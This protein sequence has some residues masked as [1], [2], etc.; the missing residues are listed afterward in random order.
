VA[1]AKKKLLPKDF[2]ALLE[3]GDMAALRAVFASRE[4]DARGFARS[5]ALAHDACPDEL[6][7]WL[8]AQGADL[9]ARSTYGETPLLARAA[10]RY[11]GRISVLLELGADIHAVDNEGNTSLHQAAGASNVA[12]VRTLL[13]HG[14]RPD[15]RNQFGLTP[16]EWA[17]Q[18]CQNI[19]I[20]SLA[21][22]A[23]ML[24]DAAPAP[25]TGLR[26]LAA[27][28]IG[29]RATGRPG[30]TRE[31]KAAVQRIG[32][33]FEFHRPGFNR[34][35]LDA[36]DAGLDHLYRLFDVPP[37]PRRK[38]YDGGSPILAE[39]SAWEDR[40]QELWELLVPP[41]G[42]ATTVQG[43]VI[44]ASGRIRVE[45]DL[46]GAGNWDADYRKM[47]S[48]LLRHLGSGTPLSEAEI[49]E[50]AAL[51]RDVKSSSYDT[52]R[53]CQLATIWVGLNPQPIELPPPAYTR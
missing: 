7:R 35:L 2:G 25:A 43:E 3:A 52:R 20:E 11:G 26:G 28:L 40:H 46:N 29:G 5:T 32:T 37:V 8:V 41:S 14:A 23:E 33:N 6:S 38:I 16:L 48:A 12:S 34:D 4:I 17:L 51:L 18:R 19:D 22:I 44:R 39:A 13:Q 9:E 15:Q 53:L 36:A 45:I 21:P 1:K 31:M 42:A 50:A 27:R 49:A 24:L 30:V 47:A 10:R